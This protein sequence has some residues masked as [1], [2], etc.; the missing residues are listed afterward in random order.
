[1]EALVQCF[2][3]GGALG[4]KDLKLLQAFGRREFGEVMLVGH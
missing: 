3:R 4:M 1:M 2:R